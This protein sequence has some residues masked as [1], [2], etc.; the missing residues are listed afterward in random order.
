MTEQ[1]DAK[2]IA[3]TRP[4]TL[5]EYV[6]DWLRAR[7]LTGAY[8]PGEHISQ[9]SV[10]DELK[11]SRMPVREAFKRLEAEGLINFKPYCGVVVNNLSLDTINEIYE[12]RRPLERLAIQK[13][14]LYIKSSDIRDLE[15]LVKEMQEN[16][17][18]NIRFMAVN[19]RFHMFLYELSR[20]PHLMMIISNL[21]DITEPYRLLYVS[22]D[23]N[24]RKAIEEHQLILQALKN[25]DPDDACAEI[26]SHHR[27]VI[28]AISQKVRMG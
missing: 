18:D 16:T 14:C 20:M 1:M 11:V 4:R 3:E 28:Q 2:A 25:R 6:Y 13:A 22:L 5:P 21:W 10:S 15:A 17:D 9:Q 7:I 24:K 23:G 27:D 8:Q 19:R 26:V 12:I